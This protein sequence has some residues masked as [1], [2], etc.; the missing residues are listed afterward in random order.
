MA[1]NTL[2]FE[3]LN[4]NKKLNH[5]FIL[6][7][8]EDHI[9][10]NP[11]DE[12]KNTFHALHI[13]IEKGDLFSKEIYFKCVSIRKKWNGYVPGMIK[14]YTLSD[15]DQFIENTLS[16]LP[17]FERKEDMISLRITPSSSISSF[18]D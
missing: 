7:N 3:H 10:I 13:C 14:R 17:S 5:Y 18:E 11:S 8:K 6:K 4:E 1:S 15:L 16:K 12:Y 2:L 9:E